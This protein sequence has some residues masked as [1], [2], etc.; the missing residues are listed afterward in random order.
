EREKL[1]VE[2]VQVV[3]AAEQP[4]TLAAD[5]CHLCGPSAPHGS[6]HGEVPLLHVA[7]LRVRILETDVLA[8]ECTGPAAGAEGL[9]DAGRAAGKS[10][11]T[12]RQ[13][14]RRGERRID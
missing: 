6:L 13:A 8:A 12:L 4:R 2:L 11:R 5:I 14:T 3:I 1:R 7:G 9:Q 10:K